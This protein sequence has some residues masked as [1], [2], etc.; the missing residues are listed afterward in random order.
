[1][2]PS[3][4]EPAPLVAVVDG[5]PASRRLVGLLLAARGYRVAEHETGRAALSHWHRH[6]A[7]QA[8]V[9]DLS[10]SDMPALQ[11][12]RQ[13][14][15]ITP[16][17]TVIALT[18]GRDPQLA[19]DAMRE[20]AYDHLAKP[21]EPDRMVQAVGR[22]VERHH[23]AVRLQHLERRVGSVSANE[24]T[25][26]AAA[27]SIVPLPE[28]ERREIERALKATGGSVGK[29]AKLLGMSRATLYRRLAETRPGNSAEAST[30]V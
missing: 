9:V 25:G 3:R 7:P 29:A 15:E 11:L 30:A 18:P 12:F 21:I 4:N 2:T 17:L 8:C 20:G 24:A 13:L 10:L 14:R 5:D 19:A 22:A 27:D 6:D 26:G 23:L 16:N 28:L 1:M